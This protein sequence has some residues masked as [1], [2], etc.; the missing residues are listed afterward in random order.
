MRADPATDEPA[1]PVRVRAGG[2]SLAIPGVWNSSAGGSIPGLAFEGATTAR[3]DATGA[4]LVAG[5]T[6]GEGRTLLPAAFVE[7]LGG[8]PSQ[9]DPVTLGEI[10]AYRYIGLAVEELAAPVTRFVVPTTDG[11]E[12]IAC[13]GAEPAFQAA[14]AGAATTLRMGG[15][16][17]ARSI[18]P[19]AAY[20]SLLPT[21]LSALGTGR[22]RLRGRLADGGRRPTPGRVSSRAARP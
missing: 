7:R 3:P 19:D 15:G 6:R 10:E 9:D 12:T 14:C 2:G 18:G 16:A 5:R 13:V 8:P 17:R 20:A 21:T 4:R 1:P 11:V 22:T